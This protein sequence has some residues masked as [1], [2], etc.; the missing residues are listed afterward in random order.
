[1]N[2]I[3]SNC[4]APTPPSAIFCPGCGG[5]ITKGEVT[6]Q[7]YID[8][9]QQQLLEADNDKIGYLI[10][11]LLGNNKKAT[12][13][14]TFTMPN[15]KEQLIEFTQFCKS[16]ISHSFLKTASESKESNAWEGKYKLGLQKLRL[17]APNDPQVQILLAESN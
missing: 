11:M 13:I 7:K 16:N 3:C 15:D 5:E 12:I 17:M 10:G 2:K 8:K 14:N 9:L 4:G 6:G 1:M